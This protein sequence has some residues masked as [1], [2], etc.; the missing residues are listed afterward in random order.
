MLRSLVHDQ[1][2]FHTYQDLQDDHVQEV[3]V[4]HL[5]VIPSIVLVLDIQTMG[6]MRMQDEMVTNVLAQ[7]A[8]VDMANN[9]LYAN[10][11]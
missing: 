10:L 11:D 9:V 1:M 4:A 6:I 7:D 2:G 5:P 8:K 3:V